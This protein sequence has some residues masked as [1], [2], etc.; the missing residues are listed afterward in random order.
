MASR[1]LGMQQRVC[2]L[3]HGSKMW[4][5]EDNMTN[6]AWGMDSRF[7]GTQYEVRRM[8]NG[9]ENIEVGVWQVEKIPCRRTDVVWEQ[10]MK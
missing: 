6:A 4:D 10:S 5:E 3:K 8:E 7:C 1:A 9:R 2:R